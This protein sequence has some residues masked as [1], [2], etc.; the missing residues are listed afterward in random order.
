[1]TQDLNNLYSQKFG[2]SD[3]FVVG[4][5]RKQFFFAFFPCPDISSG[6][7]QGPLR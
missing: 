2:M 1:M 4:T 7:F 6:L 5:T 3:E